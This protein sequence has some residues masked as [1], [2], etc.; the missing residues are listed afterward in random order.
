MTF[1]LSDCYIT[2]NMTRGPKA[3]KIPIVQ[4]LSFCGLSARLSACA[5]VSG[6]E[7]ICYQLIAPS[8][9]KCMLQSVLLPGESTHETSGINS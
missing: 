8:G 9:S 6:R 4:L 7:W 5:E 1:P 2:D 3:Q